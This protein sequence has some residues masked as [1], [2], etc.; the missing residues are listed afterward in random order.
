MTAYRTVNN[1]HI[2]IVD[3]GDQPA[4]A[5]EPQP[6]AKLVAVVMA[7]KV[8]TTDRE[9]AERICALLNADQAAPDPVTGDPKTGD[10][11][12]DSATVHVDINAAGRQVTVET[13]GEL[14]QVVDVALA[15]WRA[16]DTTERPR[17][18]AATGFQAERAATQTY[19]DD[20]PAVLRADRRREAPPPA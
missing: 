1:W 17:L 6:D 4:D 12:T 7:G 11:Q 5:G 13:P 15:T 20:Y 14:T 16:T 19:G 9:L 8:L 3:E 2:V 10:G 18:E